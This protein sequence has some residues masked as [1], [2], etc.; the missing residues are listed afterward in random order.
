M[1][2]WWK[3]IFE[4]LG[5]KL[6]R[7]TAYHPQTDGQ[8]EHTNQTVEIALQYY[9]AKYPDGALEWK[10]ILPQMQFVFNNSINASTGKA[11]NDVCY[12]FLPREAPDLIPKSPEDHEIK[13]QEAADS[14]SYAQAMMK[15]RYDATHIAWTPEAGDRVYLRMQHYN[16]PG[17]S[18]RKLT[19][20]CVGPFLI[21]RLVERLACKLELPKN[22]KIHPV[23][24]IAELEPVPQNDPYQRTRRRTTQAPLHEAPTADCLL[25]TRI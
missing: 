11:P 13:R 14:L 16:I 4:R 20:P 1:S 5:T 22:W 19:E 3:T 10:Y 17:M 7:S 9:M 12:G 15:I 24:S 8:L 6:L 21:K 18:N 25:D 23:I 2:A